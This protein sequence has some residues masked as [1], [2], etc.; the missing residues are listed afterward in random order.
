MCTRSQ[1][2]YRRG[3][4]PIKPIKPTL[5]EQVNVVALQT[6]AQ[7]AALPNGLVDY[8]SE[9]AQRFECA[10]AA[11][12]IG[13]PPRWKSKRH[14]PRSVGIPP[15][16]AALRCRDS[17]WWID[18]SRAGMAQQSVQPKLNALLRWLCLKR[19]AVATLT[20]CTAQPRALAHAPSQNPASYS[21]LLIPSSASSAPIAMEIP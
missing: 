14:S 2:T 10:S 16:S 20:R 19:C 7:F 12:S 4:K 11:I 6:V 15:N 21:A 1:S 9:V 8:G 3:N 13:G 18:L 5:I 17:G